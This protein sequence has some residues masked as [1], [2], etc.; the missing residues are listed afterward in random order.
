MRR[1]DAK[2]LREYRAKV[3]AGPKV[4]PESKLCRGCDRVLP[5]SEFHR[6][7]REKCGLT[8]RCKECVS[9]K[10]RRQYEKDPERFITRVRSYYEKA[11]QE[12]EQFYAG[13]AKSRLAERELA[14]YGLTVEAFREMEKRQCGKC[15]VCHRTPEEVDGHRSRRLYVD[16]CHD[17]GAIRGLLCSRCNTAIG[18]FEHCP[19]RLM[20]AAHYLQQ[21]GASQDAEEQ[22]AQSVRLLLSVRREFDGQQPMRANGGMAHQDDGAPQNRGK[23]HQSHP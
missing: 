18:Y 17:T 7:S 3:K 4:V 1:R 6:S 11:R 23:V 15:A 2:K 8:N 12:R 19:E 13:G 10:F 14:K 21:F 5:A 22:N 20:S 16:H 9:K